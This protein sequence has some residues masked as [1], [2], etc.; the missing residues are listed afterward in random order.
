MTCPGCGKLNKD[1][2]MAKDHQHSWDKL[3]DDLF[4][5]ALEINGNPGSLAVVQSH[6]G[7]VFNDFFDV[8][9][10]HHVL[11]KHELWNNYSNDLNNLLLL[12]S[13]CNS[14]DKKVDDPKTWFEKA[15]YFGKAFIKFVGP[16]S[17]VFHVPKDGWGN[18]AR[19]WLLGQI[20]RIKPLIVLDTSAH[21]MRGHHTEA[22][23]AYSEA[24]G[25]PKGVG[26]AQDRQ[27]TEKKRQ[28]RANLDLVNTGIRQL[29]QFNTIVE[30]K[31][32]IFPE[33]DGDDSEDEMKAVL[34]TKAKSAIDERVAKK[35]KVE[36]SLAD[37]HH[38][39]PLHETVPYH[40]ASSTEFADILAIDTL[41]HSLVD[42]A[43]RIA[44]GAVDPHTKPLDAKDQKLVADEVG[45]QKKVWLE[46]QKAYRSNGT[47]PLE[48]ELQ[49]HL[50]PFEVNMAIIQ[51]ISS[52]PYTKS[53]TH[54]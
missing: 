19:Q 44:Y 37:L 20:K 14:T 40:E 42:K 22:F 47:F 28:A 34:K 35:R 43:V 31:K 30:E 3:R 26:A 10:D 33:Y 24:K 18:K 39:T 16:L 38:A 41:R 8:D 25:L 36:K 46:A 27:R 13:T 5:I 11:A 32:D 2:A 12:C 9:A 4:R 1:A 50:F 49:R 23:T 29:E 6:Y 51:F 48:F 21:N 54:L 15:P 45:R 53:T 52:S 17:T 7:A